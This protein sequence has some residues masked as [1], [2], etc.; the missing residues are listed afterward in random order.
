MNLLNFSAV[1]PDESG[2]KPDWEKMRKKRE[3]VYFRCGGRF[4]YREPNRESGRCRRRKYCRGLRAGTIMRECYFGERQFVWLPAVSI[5]CKN[6]FS[7]H[8]R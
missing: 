8:I 5:A 1:L 6:K 7:S 4:R 2:C 3:I